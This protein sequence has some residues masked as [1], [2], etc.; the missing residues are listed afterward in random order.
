[1]V[2]HEPPSNMNNGKKNHYLVFMRTRN[3]LIVIGIILIIFNALS[4]MKGNVNIP[5]A[6]ASAKIGY[7]IG[8][9]LF[10]I[11]GAILLVIAYY[12]HRK[13][14]RKRKSEMTDSFLK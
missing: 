10:F 5:D 2:S 9:S 1:M 13:V 14:E 6:G 8:R 11:I 7:L 12:N 3:T 4:Y